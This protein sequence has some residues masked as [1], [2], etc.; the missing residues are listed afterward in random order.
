VWFSDWVGE[1][2]YAVDPDTGRAE[3]M[4]EVHSLPFCF[5][6]LP[7]GTLLVVNA[8]ENRLMARVP[9]GA[10]ETYADLNSLS[11]Y[12]CNEIICDPRGN[13]FVN[14]VNF[15]FPGGEF[16]PGFVGLVRPDGTTLKVGDGLAF[17]NG[18][19]LTPDGRTLIVAESFNKQFAAFDIADVGTLGPRRTWAELKDHGGDG[20]SMDAE[21]ALWAGSGKSCVRFREGGEVLQTIPVDRFC[22]SCALGGADGRT[23]FINANDWTGQIITADSAPT[24]RLYAAR[25]D[26]PAARL[27]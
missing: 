27:G 2:I 10:F 3:V 21:G 25:V 26:V 5:D 11:P 7:D 9:G 24:G 15:E 22:F 4:A 23:L 20:I 1:K 8:R 13:V 17:P 14:N 18:M 19:A 6:W 16:R 12:G